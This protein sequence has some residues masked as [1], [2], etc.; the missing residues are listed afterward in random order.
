MVNMYLVIH[1]LKFEAIEGSIISTAYVHFYCARGFTDHRFI[2][3][4]LCTVLFGKHIRLCK[5]MF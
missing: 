3:S 5:S 2:I 4:V 1:M